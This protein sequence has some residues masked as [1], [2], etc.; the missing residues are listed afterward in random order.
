MAT[1]L[2][3]TELKPVKLHLEKKNDHMSH[4]AYIGGLVHTYNNEF[5]PKLNAGPSPPQKNNRN[6]D[7][8]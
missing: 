4:P 1:S 5:I 3:K 2:K 6:T 7:I 8:Y